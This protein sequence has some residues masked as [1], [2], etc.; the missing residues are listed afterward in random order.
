MAQPTKIGTGMNVSQRADQK[1]RIAVP[2]A[3][4]LWDYAELAVVRLQIHYPHLH[5]LQGEGSIIVEECVDDDRHLLRREILH[6]VYREKIYTETLQMRKELVA[7][8]VRR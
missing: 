2:I 4:S 7:A 1:Q 5:F 6:A 3:D 8:V